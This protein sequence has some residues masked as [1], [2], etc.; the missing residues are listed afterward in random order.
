MN[1][2]RHSPVWL[3]V[4]IILGAALLVLVPSLFTR[5][6]WNPDEPRYAEV[7]REMLV[8]PTSPAL[9]ASGRP[10]NE[11]P[12]VFYYLVPHLN[13]EIYPDKPPVFFWLSALLSRL[14]LGWNS[15]RVVSLAAV[16][17]TLLLIYALARCLHEPPTGLLAAL[18]TLTT[19]LSFHIFRFGV[20]DPLLMLCTT[21]SIYAAVRAFE[22]P[23]DGSPR[24]WLVCY[25]AA[26]IGVLTKGPVA[27]VVPALVA[28]GY[29][30]LSRRDS[31]KGG[32]WHLAGALLFLLI[33]LTWLLMARY[34]GGAD[35]VN[36]IAVGQTLRR[37]AKSDSHAKPFYF[38]LLTWPALFFPWSLLLVLALVSAIRTARRQGDSLCRLA[39]VWLV[40]V[41]V[42]F[43]CFPSKRE[44]YLLPVLPA[45]GLLCARYL[46]V[47]ASGALAASQWHRHL[48]RLTFFLVGL[49]AIFIAA[50]ALSP[51][52]V[53]DRFSDS[54]IRLRT[55]EV[56]D[57]PG[58]CT[59]LR[60]Q[61]TSPD[62]S[63]GRRLWERLPSDARSVLEGVPAGKAPDK[64]A[65]GAIVEAFNRLLDAPNVFDPAQFKGIELPPD[66]AAELEVPPAARP[67]LTVRW[68]N[69]HLLAAAFPKQI[70]PGPASAP[71]STDVD[72]LVT[73]ALA[74]AAV[75]T[76]VVVLVAM[77]YGIWLPLG[78]KIELR[79]A[80]LLVGAMLCFSLLWDLGGTPTLNRVKSGRD[81]VRKAGPYLHGAHEVYQ[82]M[83]D[84]SG[85]YNL[86]TGRVRMPV[87]ESDDE[88]AA[89]LA[90][91]RH[92]AVI[93]KDNV[94]RSRMDRLNARYIAH[95]R[96]GHAP[97]AV[98]ANWQVDSP[99]PPT[100]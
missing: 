15:G 21:T 19:L 66:V 27:L 39:A 29:G 4:A 1:P 13:G 36:D 53:A 62:P 85:A 42:F 22:K 41:I 12:A 75:A 63:P 97:V 55:R 33:A 84:F 3:H 24:W 30:I 52:V 32:W 46:W 40:V 25:A 81:L 10:F 48:W 71:M 35:Y 69:R 59:R 88:L 67:G 17:G 20:L 34:H 91:D 26:G 70:A 89:L 61:A 58:F 49:V 64:Q 6:P 5:D 94:L 11:R 54:P 77:L 76:G 37:V 68:V 31:R 38:Y 65:R 86:F 98:I 82:F 2:P 14:G 8:L 60:S 96:V 83:S 99:K 9:D 28:L 44:R 90:S 74:I 73:P 18:I 43:S 7:A 100:P 87:L 92:V 93:A 50:A 45:V 57:W 79:R 23:P 16:A 80:I 47:V 78:P 51:R 56:V 72:E 95:E